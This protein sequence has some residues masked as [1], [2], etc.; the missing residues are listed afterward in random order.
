V[1]FSGLIGVDEWLRCFEPDFDN[2]REALRWARAAGDA[3]TELRI[4][5]TMLRALHHSLHAELIELADAC[6]ASVGP[7]VPDPLQ[8]RTWI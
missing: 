1:N 2:A 3:D 7:A 8:F 6:E 5:A 4:G